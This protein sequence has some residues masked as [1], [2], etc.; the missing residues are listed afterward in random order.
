MDAKTFL[1]AALLLSLPQFGSAQVAGVRSAAATPSPSNSFPPPNAM[2]SPSGLPS[3][4]KWSIGADGLVAHWLGAR[5]NGK[6]LREPINVILVDDYAA[7][8]VDAASRVIDAAKLAGYP[9]REGHSSGYQAIVGGIRYPQLPAG[10]DHAFSNQPYVLN[11]NHGR[12]FGPYRDGKS[13]VFTAAFSREQVAPLSTPKHVYNSF[14]VARDDF[15]QKLDQLTSYKI[16]GFVQL[17]NTMV[18]NPGLTTG[19][20]DGIAV[21]LKVQKSQ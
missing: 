11:N 1:S 13:W 21:R 7:N 16:V 9:V 15:T 19:D 2:V 14:N 18:G 4:G 20:H 5:Y 10:T 12:I 17:D 8:A 3:I 6:E